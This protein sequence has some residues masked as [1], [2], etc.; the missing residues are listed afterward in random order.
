MHVWSVTP[1]H[2]GPEEL[3]RRQ[4]RYDALSPAGVRVELRRHRGGRAAAAGDRAG[5]PRLRG[6]RRPAL[7]NAP[8][9]GRRA[10]ARLLPRPRRRR[11]VGRLETSGLRPAADVGLLERPRGRPVRGG[12]PQRGDRRR[13]P[14]GWSGLRVRLGRSP[15]STFWTSTSTPSTRATGGG[16]AA[17]RCRADRPGRRRRPPQRLQRRRTCRRTRRDVAGPGGRPD[18]PDPAPHRSG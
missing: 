5:G 9:R 2:V 11:A 1:I 16:R 14:A 6:P 15:A 12:H 8:D 10:D 13:G 18:R 3:A 7:R 17:R 4:A